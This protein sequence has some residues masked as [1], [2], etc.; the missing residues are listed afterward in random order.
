MKPEPKVPMS[1]AALRDTTASKATP[2]LTVGSS[3]MRALAHDSLIEM[4]R[5]MGIEDLETRTI[6]AGFSFEEIE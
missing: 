4:D 1:A 2:F 6:R 3:V 5:L